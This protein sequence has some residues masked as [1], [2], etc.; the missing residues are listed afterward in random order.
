M[1]LTRAFFVTMSGASSPPIGRRCKSQGGINQ[2]NRPLAILHC[3]LRD[4]YQLGR[5]LSNTQLEPCTTPFAN[6]PPTFKDLL[7]HSVQLW[8]TTQD[9]DSG[10]TDIFTQVISVGTEKDPPSHCVIV[11][12][13][14]VNRS[15]YRSF[16]IDNDM[17]R[18]LMHGSL[19]R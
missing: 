4:M 1:L 14:S 12:A 19:L 16:H 17:M 18:V 2:T 11:Q 13:D 10:W 7:D 9:V 3:V 6:E 8:S 15:Y 5:W